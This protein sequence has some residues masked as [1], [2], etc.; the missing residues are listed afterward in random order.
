MQPFDYGFY[1]IDKKKDSQL[2]FITVFDLVLYCD[3]K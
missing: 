1:S 3:I 2:L